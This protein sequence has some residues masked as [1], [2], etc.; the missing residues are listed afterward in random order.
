[1]ANISMTKSLI[2]ILGWT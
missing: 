1:M 2:R